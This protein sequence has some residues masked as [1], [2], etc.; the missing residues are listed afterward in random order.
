[1]RLDLRTCQAGGM[2]TETI[3]RLHIVLNDIEPATWR[4]GDVPV[5]ASPS[6]YTFFRFMP[7]PSRLSRIASRR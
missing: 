1:M 3:A 2:S 4:R 7:L 5:T 6:R